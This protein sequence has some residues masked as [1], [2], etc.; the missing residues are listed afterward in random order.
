MRQ[1]RR[2]LLAAL[3]A[4][5]LA[6]PVAVHARPPRRVV[7]VGGAVTEIVYA[8]GA[9]ER[10]VGTDSTSVFPAAAQK[11][12]RVGYMRQISAEGVLS[13]KPEIVVAT[14]EAGPP[15]VLT[16]IEAA[17]VPIRRL[18][19]RHSSESL[20]DNIREIVGVLGMTE[21]GRRL[22]AELDVHWSQTARRVA[23]LAN[24]PRVLF[25]LAHGGGVPM[26]SGA[27]TAADAM[28]GYAGAVNAVQGVDGYKPLTA[29]AAIASAP[30]VILITSQG[31]EETGGLDRLLARPGLSLTPAGRD[32]H[33]VAMDSL[34]LLGFGPRLP[35]AVA[36]LAERLR[37]S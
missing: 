7:S 32:R 17:G 9:G 34:Y 22:V 31:L 33:V 12:P 5:G 20:R 18:S 8:L 37:K 14:A 25:I 6:S 1:D 29:E 19:V 30:D 36:D 16:Q 15:A 13:L 4:A 35:A 26:V 24:R 23:S 11:L 2:R 10:L 3:C 21:E 28:I 27:G